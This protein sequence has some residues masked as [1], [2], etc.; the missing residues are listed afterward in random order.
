MDYELAQNLLDHCDI[1][2]LAEYMDDEIR[3]RVHEQY[4]PCSDLM[5]VAHY[6]SQHRAKYDK[7]FTV[8]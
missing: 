1:D 8:D 4:A 6:I 7:D 3:E 2:T 5:F